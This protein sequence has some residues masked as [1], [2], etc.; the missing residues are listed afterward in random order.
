MGIYPMVVTP[1]GT[2]IWMGSNEGTDRTRLVRLD[3]AT[4]EAVPPSTATRRSTSTRAVRSWAGLPAPLIRS[5][6]H[7]RAARRALSR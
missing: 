1:D 3:L 7:R 4:G 6:A 2:G 5:R